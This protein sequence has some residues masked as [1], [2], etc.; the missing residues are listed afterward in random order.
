MDRFSVLAKQRQEDGDNLEK[1][2]NKKAPLFRFLIDGKEYLQAGF[3]GVARL[4]LG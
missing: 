2:L 1:Y 4:S 3:E